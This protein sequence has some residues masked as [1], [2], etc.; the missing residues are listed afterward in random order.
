MENGGQKSY[1]NKK[2]QCNLEVESS[3]KERYLTQINS[4]TA[5]IKTKDRVN[6]DLAARIEIYEVEI[7]NLK[8]KLVKQG[9]VIKYQDENLLEIER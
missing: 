7:S 6:E 5:Q 3:S 1:W 8:E 2:T 4:L 9:E